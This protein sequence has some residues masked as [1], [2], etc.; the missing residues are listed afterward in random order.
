MKT[1]VVA[2]DSA[3]E[4][5]SAIAEAVHLLRSGE[6]VALPTETVY[7]LAADA[8]NVS[9]VL[10]IFEAKH[11]P[12]FDPLIVHVGS[13]EMAERIAE[14]PGASSELIRALM[15]RFWPGP[16]TFVLPRREVI[17][18]VVAAGLATVAV[19]VSAHPVFSA[20]AAEF[21]GALAAP[22]ANRFGRISPTTAEHV[23][24]ELDGRIPLIVNGGPT[25]HGLES[26]IVAIRHGQ[27]E[28]LRRGPIT[29]EELERFGKVVDPE[30]GSRVEAPG[31]SPSHYAPRTPLTLVETAA[32]FSLPAETRC[33]LLAWNVGTDKD[34]FAEVRVL[35]AEQN[36]IEAATNL[37]R[38]LRELDQAELD[39]IVAENVPEHGLGAAIMDRLRRAAAR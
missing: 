13:I 30:I 8:L 27:I 36:L 6:L 21:G 29:E 16:L 34:R 37:F 2:A 17:P 35:S 18:D 14:I 20:V 28:L 24:D 7:G 38:L 22:S 1:R 4:K 3:A 33:G 31:R 23:R 39:L 32:R 15:G 12:R 11:R 9:A 25:A 19:R 26:T 10:K 5:E